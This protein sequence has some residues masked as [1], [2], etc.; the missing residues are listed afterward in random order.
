MQEISLPGTD[1]LD[2]SFEQN[3]ASGINCP[4]H[5]TF[6]LSSC[7]LIWPGYLLGGHVILLWLDSSL[8]RSRSLSPF[9]S[10]AVLSS[11]SLGLL[12]SSVPLPFRSDLPS[13]F[14]EVRLSSARGA[15]A[16]VLSALV[17]FL[18]D[19]PDSQGCSRHSSSV[20][21]FSTSTVSIW[22]IRFRAGSP[23]ESHSGEG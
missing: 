21:R 1:R 6:S 7:H 15:Q 11:G 10:Q 23:T 22:S 4:I 20:I 8:S 3:R 2:W 17:D 14:A 12:L 13:K 9:F 18:P 5:L 19:N 16:P